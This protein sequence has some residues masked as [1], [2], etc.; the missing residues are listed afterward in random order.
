[1]VEQAGSLDALVAPVSGGG[2]IAGCG[3]AVTALRPG[4]RVIG[5]EPEAGD[6]TRRSLQAGQRVGIDV[7]R[8]IADGLQVGIPGELTFEV[9]RRLLEDVVT[10]SDDEIVQTIALLF[11]RLK[12]VVEPSGAA[13]LAAVLSGRMQI[14]GQR[15]GVILSG[16]NIS[17]E[18]FV[19]IV[20]AAGS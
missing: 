14:A 9:N 3:T 16:G 19:E 7:P 10:A 12:I 15:V 5:V 6:D 2:L 1:L 8:T 17:A 13:G 18:R 11:E 4:V 20:T